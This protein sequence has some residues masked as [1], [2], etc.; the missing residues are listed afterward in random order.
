M[1]HDTAKLDELTLRA[2]D[3]E[4]GS[5]DD[6]YFSDDTW[7]IRYLVVDTGGWLT[8]RKVLISPRAVQSL[9]FER[10]ELRLDLTRDRIESS[11]DFDSDKPVS[12]QYET[13]YFGY[14]GYPYYWTGPYVWGLA[15]YPVFA[16]APVGAPDVTSPH[17][18][19]QHAERE[20]AKS[21][22][23][24]RSAKE[25]SGYRVQAK[26]G[27]IGHIETFLFDE[28]S[29][30]IAVVV[31]DT[32]NWWPG[33]HVIIPPRWIDDIDWAG[34]EARVR[35]ARER[36]KSS[37]EYEPQVATTHDG[38]QQLQKQIEHELH[39]GD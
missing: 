38:R 33:K 13:E 15:E 2:T 27:E 10:K 6:V 12:R 20:R 21:D 1:L 22:P 5:V 17:V 26:D 30:S 36:I 18:V 9:D 29:W 31:V 7:T 39:F 24:L 34:K 4:I 19:G 23:H 8:G 14:Y 25:V 35:V 37:A 28:A 11:P 32:K 16:G 3:G